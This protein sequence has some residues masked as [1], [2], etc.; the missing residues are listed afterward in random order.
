MGEW[1]I[2]L[3]LHFPVENYWLVT[4]HKR[5]KEGLAETGRRVCCMSIDWEEEV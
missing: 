3:R 1:N 4:V 5:G 2:T